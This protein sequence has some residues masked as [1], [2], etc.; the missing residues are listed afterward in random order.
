M[1]DCRSATYYRYWMHMIHHNNPGHFGIRTKDY[2]LIFYYGLPFNM[3]DMGKP[4]MWW[5]KDA[6]TKVTQTP[7]AWELYDL[8][9]DPTEFHNVY[10]NP[11][12]KEISG[13]LKKQLQ[14]T[15]ADLN[16]TDAKYP[17]IQKVIDDHWND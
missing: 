9:K 12:Y 15:R 7:A 14:E 1:P 13:K 2:K 6:S 16:E 17:H 11:E 8:R 10:H 3:A 5:I 4:T